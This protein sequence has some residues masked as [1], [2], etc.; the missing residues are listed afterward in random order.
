MDNNLAV[1][2]KNKD[3]FACYYYIWKLSIIKFTTNVTSF[4]FM[5][6]TYLT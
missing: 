1:Y 4:C 2:N 6:Q 3:T 5:L